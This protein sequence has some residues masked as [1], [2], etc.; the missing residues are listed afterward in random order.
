MSQRRKVFV[1]LNQGLWSDQHAVGLELILRHQAQ[2]DDVTAI[3]C[4]G[5]LEGCAPNSQHT[6]T[7]C[8][9]CI[10]QTQM[11]FKRLNVSVLRKEIRFSRAPELS[12]VGNY[13]ELSEW[14]YRGQRLG[15]LIV[16]QLASEL[17]TLHN[18]VFNSARA[19]QLMSVASQLFD[20]AYDY[21][22]ECDSET[23]VYVWNGRRGTDGPIGLAARAR[24]LQCRYFISGSSPS[25]Y[26]VLE[27]P[28]QEYD[29]WRKSIENH[30]VHN[31]PDEELAQQF[32]NSRRYGGGKEVDFQWFAGAFSDRRPIR[33]SVK[34]QEK[35][36]LSL[37]TSTPSELL[38]SPDN[39]DLPKE[40]RSAH[41]LLSWLSQENWF[42]HN[43]E[44]TVRW[45]PNLANAN[46][47]EMKEMEETIEKTKVFFHVRP[48]SE[49]N[50]YL[51][52]EDSDLVLSMG[53]T[54]GIESVWYGKPVILFGNA[55]WDSLPSIR[56]VGSCAQLKS[57]L[58]TDPLRKSAREDAIKFGS[59]AQSHGES[60][61]HL[62]YDSRRKIYSDGRRSISPLTSVARALGI[63]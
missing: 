22:E 14:T 20:F 7:R 15:H 27:G 39:L 6:A 59:W 37:F 28:I 18:S 42:T 60:F 49:D 32:Y 30:F 38:T 50:S 36:R 29:S 51:L 41:E 9:A 35:L 56:K 53:S 44:L 54:M 34:R 10:L 48:D 2:G 3:T 13:E 63:S 25:K 17:G 23:L 5:S 24:G 47:V 33:S 55:I 46:P 4:R 52:A 11:S 26:L 45:H 40:S 8:G 62:A 21:F 57:I 58:L 61:N 19:R 31:R 12:P 43:F 16:S 1:A